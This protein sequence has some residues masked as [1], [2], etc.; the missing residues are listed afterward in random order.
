M[1][2]NAEGQSRR[3]YPKSTGKKDGEDRSQVEEEGEPKLKACNCTA[4]AGHLSLPSQGSEFQFIPSEDED[5]LS[6]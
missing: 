5:H 6:G 1:V 3:S 2:P 4:L